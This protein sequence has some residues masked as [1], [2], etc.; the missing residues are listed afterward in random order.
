VVSYFTSTLD[1]IGKILKD[2]QISFVKLDGKV[3]GKDRE[4]VVNSFEK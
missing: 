3:D 4:V 2:N 1:F